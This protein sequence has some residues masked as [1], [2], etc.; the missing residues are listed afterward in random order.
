MSIAI[1]FAVGVAVGV[2]AAVRWMYNNIGKG[3]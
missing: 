2:A 3:E 1:S